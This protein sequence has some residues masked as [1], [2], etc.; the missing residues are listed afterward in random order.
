M[1]TLMGFLPVAVVTV[2]FSAPAASALS[3]VGPTPY[4]D[5]SY[6]GG[7]YGDYYGS[8]GDYYDPY[9]SYGSGGY[10]DDPYSYGYDGYDY[11]TCGSYY[12]CSAYPSYNYS[13]GYDSSYYYPQTSSYGYSS[14]YYP[15]SYYSSYNMY[16]QPATYYS[17]G[18]TIFGTPLC[19]FPGYGNVAC[20][21]DP[22]QP[23]YDYWTGHW[24]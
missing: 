20:G 19:S 15:T 10:Y 13:Y 8:Y 2:L 14:G 4:Y 11:G 9:Y 1:K 24:Y 22:R 12:G 3:M 18:S 6:Y 7:G 17:G 23:V 5:G 16:P 21:T